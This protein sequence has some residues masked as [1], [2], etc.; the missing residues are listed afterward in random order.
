MTNYQFL[1]VEFGC[2]W[3]SSLKEQ[4]EGICTKLARIEKSID[5][6]FF[7]RDRAIDMARSDMERRLEGMNEFRAQLQSQ[8]QTFASV[9]EIELK[10][11][12][13][14]SHFNL[15]ANSARDRIDMIERLYSERTGSKKWSDYII[16]VLISMGIFIAA[17]YILKF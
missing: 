15:L 12:K 13:M 16:T 3:F 5:E 8:A 14:E 11:D 7:V 1:S 2:H 4:I 10:F 6:K 17:K 9:K